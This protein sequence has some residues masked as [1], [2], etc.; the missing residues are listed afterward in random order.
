MPEAGGTL[1]GKL[2]VEDGSGVVEYLT[3]PGKGDRQSR[4]GFFRSRRHQ[5]EGLRYWQANDE[6]GVYLGLWHTHPE[7]TPK[8]SSVDLADW[9]RAV[10]EDVYHGKG[11]IFV[12]VGTDSIGFWHGGANQQLCH[13][14]HLKHQNQEVGGV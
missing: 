1:L 3:L 12:I 5:R 8:P 7:A 2:L 10:S 9:R 14:G 4:F 11:I 6:T 13:L